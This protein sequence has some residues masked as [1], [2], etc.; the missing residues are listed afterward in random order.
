MK[1]FL[2]ILAALSLSTSALSLH[3]TNCSSAKGELSRV[4]QETWGANQIKW[5]LDG[6]LLPPEAEVYMDE[7]TLVQISGDRDNGHY[8]VDVSVRL[9]GQSE[10]VVKKVMCEAWRNGALD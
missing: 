10:S 6:E 8:A 3:E 2:S 5:Y 4:E 1:K 9:P 7:S